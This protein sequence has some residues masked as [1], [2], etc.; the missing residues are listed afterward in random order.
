LNGAVQGPHEPRPVSEP[1]RERH[2]EAQGRGEPFLSY[3]D[4]HG[5]L[6]VLSLPASWD[7]VTIGRSSAAHIPLT[8]DLEVST[9]HAQIERIGGEWVLVDDGLSR[10][11]SYV[12]GER[13]PGRRRLDDEDELR[14]GRTR[15]LF[16]APLRAPR[17]ATII[18]RAAG[19]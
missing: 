10:N 3:R 13:I 5:G 17:D 11:G 9:V 19:A 15:M 18:P 2:R 8:W 4:R 16:H 6:I 7:R 1:E 12:N 14:F